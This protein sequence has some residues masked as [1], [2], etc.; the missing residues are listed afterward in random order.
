M[1]LDLSPLRR[2]RDFRLRTI[3]ASVSSFGSFF[4]M[5]AVPI[6]IKQLTN[7][8]VAVGLVG[9]VEFV[10]IIV[11]GLLGGAIADRFA[12]RVRRAAPRCCCSTRCCP[13]PGC[14]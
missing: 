9:A 6:Q 11:V 3:A 14:G 8:T 12:P 4:T 13:R 5:V 2:Y 10:P 7:S 1:T